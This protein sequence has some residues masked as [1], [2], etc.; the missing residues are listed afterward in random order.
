VDNREHETIKPVEIVVKA[1]ARGDSFMG[2]GL[3]IISTIGNGEMDRYYR[4]LLALPSTSILVEHLSQAHSGRYS[5]KRFECSGGGA[6]G[7]DRA[8]SGFGQIVSA[9][10]FY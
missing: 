3:L 8:R 1:L 4:M 2:L 9:C 7:E 5:I 10:A 6:R